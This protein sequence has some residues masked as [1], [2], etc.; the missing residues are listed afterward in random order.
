MNHWL[1]CLLPRAGF[2]ITAFPLPVCC[3]LCAARLYPL[4]RL[5]SLLRENAK[6]INLDRELRLSFKFIEEVPNVSEALATGLNAEWENRWRLA[7]VPGPEL[8]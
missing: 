8:F 3:Q 1:K 7:E 5:F 4:P 2:I 6:T